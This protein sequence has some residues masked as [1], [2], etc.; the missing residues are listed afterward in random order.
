MQLQVNLLPKHNRPKPAVRI[1]PV[2]LVIAFVLNIIGMASWWLF[3]QLDLVSSISTLQIKTEE[4]QQLEVQVQE[5]EAV[6][7]LEAE[8]AAKRDFIRETIAVSP[9]WHPMLEAVERAMVPGLSI[10][11]ITASETGDVTIGGDTDTVKS[12]ADFLGSLQVE[13]GLPVIRISSA[14][15]ESAFQLTLEAWSGRE[16]E[17]D[18]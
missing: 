11:G 3:L 4:V 1:W 17:E 5:A 12:V 8:V 2:V 13:T 16:V 7:V 10:R 9:C 18:E 15:P 6:A 14:T